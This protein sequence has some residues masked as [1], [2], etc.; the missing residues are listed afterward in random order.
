MIALSFL[1]SLTVAGGL[2]LPLPRM[3]DCH[4]HVAK[5]GHWTMKVKYDCQLLFGDG[6]GEGDQQLEDYVKE[7]QEEAETEFGWTSHAEIRAKFTGE[8]EI[9]MLLSCESDDVCDLIRLLRDVVGEEKASFSWDGNCLMLKGTQRKIEENFVSRFL[10]ALLGCGSAEMVLT[11][12]GTISVAELPG[13]LDENHQRF[14]MDPAGDANANAHMRTLKIDG[15]AI[16]STR[17]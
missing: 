2:F 17:N 8:R 6:P 15:L 4:V 9:E 3:M 14:V 16:D 1:T 5:G 10:S 13:Q 7:M 12:D 11:A